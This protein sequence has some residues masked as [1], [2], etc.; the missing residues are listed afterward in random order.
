MST[1]RERKAASAGKKLVPDLALLLVFEAAICLGAG[2]VFLVQPMVAKMIL[3][4]L[5]GSQAV[6]NTS[7]LFFQAA[8]LAGYAYAHFSIR[9]LGL[10]KQ[11]IIHLFVLFLPVVALPGW[12]LN[13]GGPPALWVL[14][15]LALVGYP[16]V[17]EPNFS[18]PAQT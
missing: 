9:G 16:L 13:V 3:P 8:L 14:A 4:I 5:G 7:M 11:P 10:K 6:W 12:A 17:I 2:L 1:V 15:L 18:I